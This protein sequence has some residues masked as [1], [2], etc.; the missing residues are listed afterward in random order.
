MQAIPSVCKKDHSRNVALVLETCKARRQAFRTLSSRNNHYGTAR[1]AL[2]WFVPP[3]PQPNKCNPAPAP[4]PC[5]V[6]RRGD[7][8]DDLPALL[9]PEVVLGAVS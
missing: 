4:P 9:A 5:L 8:V 7:E 1:A 3:G 6:E 2:I